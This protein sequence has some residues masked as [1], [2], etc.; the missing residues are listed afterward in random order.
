MPIVNRA[1]AEQAFRAAG[2]KRPFSD[3]DFAVAQKHG[4]GIYAASVANIQ[5][6]Q[7]Q[8]QNPDP[9]QLV[10]PKTAL[11][12]QID[13]LQG[14]YNTTQQAQVSLPTLV[15]TGLAE[16]SPEFALP[17]EALEARYGNPQSPLYIQNPFVRQAVIEK[18]TSSQQ[19]AFTTVADKIN[20]TLGLRGT[21]ENQQLT[22]LKDKYGLL[23]DEA[24]TAAD[25]KQQEFDNAV[26]LEQ[27]AID[28]K[29]A[30]SETGNKTSTT[31]QNYAE[32]VASG[33]LTLAQV[34]AAERGSV[35]NYVAQNGID[36][37]PPKARDSIAA[38]NSA[39]EVV[40]QIKNYSENLNKS[41]NVFGKYFGGTAAAIRGKTGGSNDA[42]SASRQL[43][44][45]KQGLASTLSRGLGEKGVLTDYDIKRA[46]ALIPSPY[47]TKKE[48]QNKIK[49]LDDFFSGIE[50]RAYQTATGTPGTL[51]LTSGNNDTGKTSSGLTYTISPN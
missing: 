21:I 15:K 5:K 30:G 44:L 7:Q 25:A 18:A 12:Q 36:I 33:Q 24:K 17:R 41:T 26:K 9:N 35:V 16:K 46:Q 13:A 6:L 4:T 1:I 47:D 39:R 50:Q 2:F 43:G 10:D 40:S 3:A 31:A 19:N 37:L 29:K 42:A 49:L 20:Q 23:K 8:A 38:V 28:R 51:N 32:L 14:Q 45:I 48:A 27:L 22:G 11:L 34:P